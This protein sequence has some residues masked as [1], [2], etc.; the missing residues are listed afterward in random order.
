MSF[1]IP[2]YNSIE[3]MTA[4]PKPRKQVNP[5]MADWFMTGCN[6]T[7]ALAVTDDK[8]IMGNLKYLPKLLK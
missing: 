4:I 6:P 3:E 5:D 2:K 8:T 1:W 7:E